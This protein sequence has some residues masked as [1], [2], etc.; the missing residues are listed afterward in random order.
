MI[1]IVNEPP[2]PVDVIAS[3]MATPTAACFPATVKVQNTSTGADTYSWMLWDG[4]STVAASN[5]TNP[6]FKI[7][8]PGTYRL[9]LTATRSTTGESATTE[10][11]DIKILDV[12]YAAFNTSSEIVYTPDTELKLLNFSSRAEI[13]QWSFGDGE[14]SIFIEPT[15][16]YQTAGVYQITLLAGIDHGPQDI[17]GDGI[18]DG[19]LVCYDTAKMQITARDGG[20]IR[21]PNAFTPDENGPTGGHAHNAGF[22]DVFLPIMQGVQSYRMQIFDRW[23][24][25]IFQTD[26]ADTGWDGYNQAGELMPAGVYVYKIDVTLSNGTKDARVGD[27]GLIR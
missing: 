8:A 9:Q 19:S 7:S 13:Y 15:H 11:Q 25:K 6:E 14:T 18:T 22:N 27:V 26:D 12:P 5:L 16:S 23:G 20:Y 17:D 24:T 4:S 1:I 3:F 10:S 2:P 21:I